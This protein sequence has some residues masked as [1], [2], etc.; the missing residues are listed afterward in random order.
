M[1]SKSNKKT[2]NYVFQQTSKGKNNAKTL[3]VLSTH[4]KQF[5]SHI[6]LYV[7]EE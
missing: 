7:Y 6:Y 3:L 4:Y 2:I 5:L 1:S